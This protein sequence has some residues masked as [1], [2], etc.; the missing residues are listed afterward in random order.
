VVVSEQPF[1][2]GQWTSASNA[3]A[4][5]LCPGRHQAQR[6]IAQSESDDASHGRAIHLALQK[7]DPAG[8]DF[9]QTETYDAC[10][11][12]FERELRKIFGVNYDRATVWREVRLHVT[13]PALP[14][15]RSGQPT[16]F[17]PHSGQL[18]CFV[19]VDKSAVVIEWKTLPGDIPAAAKNEQIRDQIVLLARQP[20]YPLQEVIGLVIQPLVTHSPEPVLYTLTDIA[21][22]E[23]RMFARVIASNAPNAPRVAGETQCKYCL[24]KPTCR[25]YQTFAGALVPAVSDLLSIPV[26]SWTPA[27]R[28]FFADRIDAAQK[29]LDETWAALK[30]GAELD[31]NFVPGYAM[32]PGVVKETVSDV[33]TL[34]ERFVKLATESKLG[35]VE[36]ATSAFVNSCAMPKGALK[37]VVAL[38]TGLKGMKLKNALDTL[39]LGITESKQSAPSLVKVKEV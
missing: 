16:A 14:D 6:G 27:Q 5:G 2:R 30:A 15:P 9:A 20:Q 8:L 3:A 28:T 18:D 1:Q 31:P 35:S 13:V 11:K 26:A 22:A 25:E 34:F 37:E 32:K 10:Q 12:I 33:Q 23:K 7:Q 21:E 17:Y 39:L 4:D 19:I 24:A 29:F 38:A 36:E